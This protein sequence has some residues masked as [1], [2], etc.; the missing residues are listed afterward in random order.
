MIP[1]ALRGDRRLPASARPDG[2]GG[3]DASCGRGSARAT[4]SSSGATAR[5]GR[6][7]SW[8]RRSGRRSRRSSAAIEPGA[9][10][11][12]I[13]VAG[14]TDSHWLREAF[15]TVA[16][17]FFPM[18][19]MS[20]ELA[21]RLIHS[22]DERIPVDDLE[23]GVEFLRHVASVGGTGGPA[24]RLSGIRPTASVTESSRVGRDVPVLTENGAGCSGRDGRRQVRLGGMALQNGV[25][26]HG[27]TSW[28]VPFGRTK[29][30]SRRVG[31]ERAR[32][33]VTNP[34]LRGPARLLD[35]FAAA[36]ADPARLPGGAAAVRAAAVV[37]GSMV[38]SCGG[39]APAAAVVRARP[40]PRGSCSAARSR[41]CRRRWRCAAP[42]W[43]PTTAPSTSRSA[44][45][46]HGE[47]RGKEHERCGSHLIGPLLLTFR[48]RRARSPRG[49]RSAFARCRARRRRPSARSPPRPRSS[50]WMVRHPDHPVAR[51]LAR[52]GHELQHRLATAEP[53]A[54]QLE[55]AEA[56]L[57]GLPRARSRRR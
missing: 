11:A 34:L 31:R 18:R 43:P 5:A 38:A 53:D 4:T 6:A 10:L 7:R 51:A 22:A 13:C 45:Y 30:S 21:A 48:G 44:R 50:R 20:A 23:L 12:P 24:A 32:A 35:A 33:G 2:G 16:Y 3:R 29:A 49:R 46:E 9:R 1:G 42:S 47:P 57:A 26:V 40:V 19:T 39:R 55:V 15:G 56:A 36:A 17:G 8:G 54:A 37:L 14:F 28:A 41:C 25:L 52:P 27:P